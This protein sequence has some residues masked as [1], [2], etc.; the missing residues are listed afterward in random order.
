MGWSFWW[1]GNAQATPI[2]GE[3]PLARSA[4]QYPAGGLGGHRLGAFDRPRDGSI[5][6]G[7]VGRGDS[8]DGYGDAAGDVHVKVMR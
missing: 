2:L 5:T 3:T 7:V 1:M 8:N 4:R 6:V